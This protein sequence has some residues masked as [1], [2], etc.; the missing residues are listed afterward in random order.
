MTNNKLVRA[1]GRRLVLLTSMLVVAYGSKVAAEPS[2]AGSTISWP[3][4]GW[5]QVQDSETFESICEGGSSCDVESGVFIVINHTTG[6]RWWMESEVVGMGGSSAEPMVVGSTISWSSDGWYQVQRSDSFESLCEGGTNCEVDAGEYIVINHTSGQRWESIMV[7]AV[8]DDVAPVV[9]GETILFANND[10]YQV[11]DAESYVALCEGRNSCD[12]GPGNYVVINLTTGLR[13][14]D[15][16][17]P[18]VEV[19]VHDELPIEGIGEPDSPIDEPDGSMDVDDPID[20]DDPGDIGLLVDSDS[21]GIEDM[22]DNCPDNFNPDQQ[23]YEG[24][25]VG[26]VCDVIAAECPCGLLENALS[27]IPESAFFDSFS[28]ADVLLGASFVSPYSIERNYRGRELLS[29]A[30]DALLNS[31]FTYQS[32]LRVNWDDGTRTLSCGGFIN[33]QV[34]PDITVGEF[35][36][37]FAD[38]VSE[39]FADQGFQEAGA[40]AQLIY[41]TDNILLDRD[42]DGVL[43]VEDNCIGEFNPQQ[44]NTGVTVLGDACS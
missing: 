28:T 9:D 41:G 16:V 4:D 29:A 37:R 15:F 8:G 12:V 27:E 44:I 38:S 3:D 24:N 7:G 19:V 17:V 36:V 2:L 21:D 18:E 33:P 39:E 14:N 34:V 1:Q 6:Q 23:D 26:N 42:S 32:T 11:Q 43:D 13:I 25:G 40:C 5:Y 22:F 10:W 20:V 35:R 31:D 30:D